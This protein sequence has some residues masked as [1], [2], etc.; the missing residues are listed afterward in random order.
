VRL[1]PCFARGTSPRRTNWST[2][3]TTRSQSS[4]RG[5]RWYT[6]GQKVGS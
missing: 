4:G 3:T 6:R 2:T 1:A 5:G